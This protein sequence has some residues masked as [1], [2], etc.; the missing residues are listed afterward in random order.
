M[1][2][3][4]FITF[5]GHNAPGGGFAGGMVMAA[6]FVVRLLAD[7]REGLR[8]LRI[9]PI[10]I[11]GIGLAIAVGVTLAPLFV[12]RVAMDAVIWKWDLPLIGELKFVTSAFFDI[13]V[14]LLVVGGVVA[15]LQA[16][17]IGDEAGPPE[18]GS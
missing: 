8:T 7:G 1:L 16:F 17:A 13:G 12:G 18:A 4:L 10:V 3:S 15:M 11:V 9:D 14:H 5:R 6:V 2:V